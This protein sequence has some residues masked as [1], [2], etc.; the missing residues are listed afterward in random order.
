MARTLK[1]KGDMDAAAMVSM[2]NTFEELG[3]TNGHVE[4]DMTDV[5]FIDSSGIGGLVSLHKKLQASGGELSAM[6]IGGQPLRL[7]KH[8]RMQTIIKSEREAKA[9]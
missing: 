8:L 9:A 5:E 2:R 6:N 1:I 4:I 3:Q 7:L